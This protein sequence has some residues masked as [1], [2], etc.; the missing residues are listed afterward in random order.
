MQAKYLHRCFSSLYISNKCYIRF[1]LPRP[2]N[3]LDIFR[4]SRSSF[5]LTKRK[6]NQNEIKMTHFWI[7]HSW[8]WL[9]F[10][11]FI[12]LFFLFI[13]LFHPM[14]YT[15]KHTNRALYS[16]HYAIILELSRGNFQWLVRKFSK[17]FLIY[18]LFICI[19]NI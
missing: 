13:H 1:T 7:H 9:V 8:L 18:I 19:Y 2:N 12:F 15:H 6:K 11:F 10:F 3:F 4:I 16:R 5:D 17:F 14:S